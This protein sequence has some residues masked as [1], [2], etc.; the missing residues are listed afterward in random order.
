MTDLLIFMSICTTVKQIGLNNS[1]LKDDPQLLKNDSAER[2][3]VIYIHTQL[4]NLLFTVFI[5]CTVS[6]IPSLFARQIV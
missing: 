6:A 4:Y 5:N 3:P 1:G 2:Q